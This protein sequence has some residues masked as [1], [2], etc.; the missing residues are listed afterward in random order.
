MLFCLMRS[1]SK[2]GPLPLQYTIPQARAGDHDGWVVWTAEDLGLFVAVP[3][4]EEH[5]TQEMES[6]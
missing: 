4:H 3:A 1:S 6:G 2:R 5:R